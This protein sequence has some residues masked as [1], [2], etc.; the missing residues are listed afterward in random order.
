MRKK[1]KPNTMFTM[2]SIPIKYLNTMSVT[3]IIFV[4]IFTQRNFA[5][6]D[7]ST[8]ISLFKIRLRKQNNV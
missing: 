8:S 5:T 2:K 3:A 1:R 6:T 7:F 4:P